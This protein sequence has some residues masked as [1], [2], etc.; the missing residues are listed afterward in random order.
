MLP[1]LL[2]YVKSYSQENDSLSERSSNTILLKGEAAIY[3]SDD[4]FN[5]QI[6]ERSIVIKGNSI[7]YTKNSGKSLIIITSSSDYVSTSRDLKNNKKNLVKRIKN[8]D[9]KSKK[10]IDEYQSKLKYHIIRKFENHHSEERFSNL[11]NQTLYYLLPESGL[12]KKIKKACLS[13]LTFFSYLSC[14]FLLVLLFDWY[15]KQFIDYHY[16][17]VFNIR[18]PPSLLSFIKF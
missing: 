16:S 7:Q 6:A 11:K 8:D 5:Y 14:L 3:S 10:I 2:F 18:P 9:I 15:N 1:F 17:R 12:K 13:F 4:N